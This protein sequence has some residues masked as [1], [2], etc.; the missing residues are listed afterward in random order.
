MTN[1]SGMEPPPTPESKPW[2]RGRI[3]FLAISGAL[4]VALLIAVREILL[5]FLLALIIAYVL[6]PLV[7]W[8]ERR[9]RLPRSVSI[10]SVYF[11]AL[12]FLTLSVVLL[13]PRMYGETLRFAQE[14]PSLA[15]QSAAK[16]GPE[17]EKRVNAYRVAV[18]STTQE[19]QPEP[20][21]VIQELEDGSQGIDIRSGVSI[22]EESPGRYRV[23]AREQLPAHGFRVADLLAQGMDKFIR[24]LELNALAVLKL[25]SAVIESTARAVFLLFMVLML[26]GY[27]MH[28]R[29]P[30]LGFFRSLVP[31]RQ[32]PS[33]DHFLKRLDRGLAGVV[34]GQLLIC[35]VNGV[36]SAIGFWLFDL[37]YWPILSLLAGVL[38][39]IPI[40]GAILSSIPAVLVGLTQDVWTAVWVLVWIVGIHQ[41]EANLLNPK[42][43]GVSAKIHPVLVVFSLLVGEHYFGL[44]G[45]L[46]AVPSLSIVQ[47]IFLH[48][49]SSVLNDAAE[50]SLETEELLRKSDS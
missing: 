4:T 48:F 41:V 21:L 50:S 7:S 20:A 24:Y 33:F 30:I 36:L 19:H 34:R 5:P 18:G 49:R 46:L 22:V 37:K 39:L 9:L 42:I 31:A 29:E 8:G 23:L 14:V 43:I 26:A 27:L 2:T 45:A 28:T 3:I 44:W 10:L 1:L 47:S 13:A 38:S 25:G 17:I 32:R 40:F 11:F 16:Y 12:T 6:M 35:L 15:R